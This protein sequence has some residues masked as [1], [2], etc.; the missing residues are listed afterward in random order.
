LKNQN[1]GTWHLL[2]LW[3]L[4]IRPGRIY[5]LPYKEMPMHWKSIAAFVILCCGLGISQEKVSA[6][7]ET[8]TATITGTLTRSDTHLPVKNA[9]VVIM[10]RMEGMSESE[11]DDAGTQ[12]YRA[13]TNTDEKGH[14]EFAD[15]APGIYYIRATHTGMVMKEAERNAT[16]VKLQAGQPQNLNLLML[17]SGAITGRVL[18][19][20]GEPLQNVSVAAMRYVYT[21]AGRRLTEAKR[22]TSDDKGEYRLFGLKPGSYLLLADTTRPSFDNG[23]ATGFVIGTNN[24]SGAAKK[25]QKVYAPTFY[26]NENSPDQAAPV[27]LKAGDETHADFDLVRVP[28]HHITGRVT[29]IVP[30]KPSD[31]PKEF[32]SF[33]TAQRQGSQFPVAFNTIAKDSSF[34]IGPVAPG[35]YKISA[36]QQ[37]S[38]RSFSGSRDVVVTNADVTN[39]TI[40]LGAGSREIHGVV[41]AESDNKID[42]SKLLVVLIPAR[43]SESI[44]DL[45]ST[46]EGLQSEGDF[47]EVGKDGSFKLDISPST[48]PYQIVLSAR[49]SGLEDW[50]TSKVIASGRDVQASGLKITE[51]EPRTLVVLVSDKGASIEGTALDMEKKPFPNAEV[52]AV[53]SD[54]KLRKRLDLIQKTTA[55][56]QG[57]FKLRGIRP[58]EYIAMALEEAEEQPFLE[59]RFLAQNSGQVQAVKVETGGKQKL[60]LMVIRAEA[61]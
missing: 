27:V 16:V 45:S 54:P 9:Q 55:D 61:Q 39:I 20:E 44:S 5:T 24:A 26:Q 10:G 15:L 3:F 59:D 34:D 52:F 13:S 48:K 25:E 35:K 22:T 14:F 11:V 41:R 32:R 49:G 50:F 46:I 36:V 53:P 2:W 33:V 28:A 43:D 56:Q 37:E 1:G 12:P 57:R 58:G 38:E 60:D 29:G 4:Q 21:I 19:E 8:K 7:Q 51:T 31:K 30:G 17:P 23:D 40:A 47:S 6:A 42:Y 18:N